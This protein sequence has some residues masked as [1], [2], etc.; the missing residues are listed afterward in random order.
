ME[1]SLFMVKIQ[2]VD[3]ATPLSLLIFHLGQYTTKIDCFAGS[4]P[5]ATL[6]DADSINLCVVKLLVD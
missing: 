4:V 1:I 5:S 6:L 3:W 2:S